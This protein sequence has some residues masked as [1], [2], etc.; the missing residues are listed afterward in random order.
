MM[1]RRQQ[2]FCFQPFTVLRLC[3]VPIDWMGCLTIRQK[4]LLELVSPMDS[5][6]SGD[7][8]NTL[9]LRRLLWRSMWGRHWHWSVVSFRF[10]PRE[11]YWVLSDAANTVVCHVFGMDKCRMNS[12]LARSRRLCANDTVLSESMPAFNQDCIGSHAVWP[13]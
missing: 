11:F 13:P 8:M 12:H 2:C 7:P 5:W 10:Q 6:S 3:A 4:S 1:P 9:S